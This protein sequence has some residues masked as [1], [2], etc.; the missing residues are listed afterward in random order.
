MITPQVCER[1]VL[2][3]LFL[4]LGLKEGEMLRD[5][6]IHHHKYKVSLALS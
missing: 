2:S 4:L 5:R 1:R 3:A 6:N